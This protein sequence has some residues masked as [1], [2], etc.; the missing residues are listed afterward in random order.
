MELLKHRRPKSSEVAELAVFSKLLIPPP[1]HLGRTPLLPSSSFHGSHSRTQAPQNGY[2]RFSD[3]SLWL[4]GWPSSPHRL[5]PP[6]PSVQPWGSLAVQAHQARLPHPCSLSLENKLL[7]IQVSVSIPFPE[8]SLSCPPTA[9]L[10]TYFH[11]SHLGRFLC[12][13]D[14]SL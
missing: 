8:R 14:H 12:G 6:S 4:Q 11:P 3:A 2:L 13:S 9:C 1:L 5:V 7:G 10:A